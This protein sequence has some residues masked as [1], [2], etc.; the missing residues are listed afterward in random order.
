MPIF[1]DKTNQGM[2]GLIFINYL[3]IMIGL[4]KLFKFKFNI[5]P[6]QYSDKKL[7]E[8]FKVFTFVYRALKW[9]PL[10]CTMD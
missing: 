10:K 3:L 2:D 1:S 7:N 6:F 5:S 4:N 8:G 9:G